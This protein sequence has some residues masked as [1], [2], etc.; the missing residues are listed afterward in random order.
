MFI[1]WLPEVL[2]SWRLSAR[3]KR[4]D[5]VRRGT[6]P[7]SASVE[8]LEPLTLLAQGSIALNKTIYEIPDLNAVPTPPN[9]GDTVTIT[10]SDPDLSTN[11]APSLSVQ[12][13]SSGGDEE[14]VNLIRQG[15]PGTSV[16]IGTMGSASSEVA[17]F[18]LQNGTLEVPRGTFISVSYV[19]ASN[20]NGVQQTIT[21]QSRFYVFGPVKPTD[22]NGANFSSTN[23]AAGNNGFTTSGPNGNNWHLSTGRGTVANPNSYYFG[24][25]EDSSAVPNSGGGTYLANRDGTLT[26]PLIDL[27]NVTDGVRLEFDQ[28]LNVNAGF[29]APAIPDTATVSVITASGTKVIA[30]SNSTV[31]PGLAK[32]LFNNT[33]TV[34]ERQTL[35]LSAFS[36]QKIQLAFR[37][38]SNADAL[39]GEGWYIDEIKLSAPLGSIE[40]TKRNDL[41][42]NGQLDLG[43]PGLAGWTMY[44]DQN[45]N[46]IQDNITTTAVVGTPQVLN[47][48]T[49]QAVGVSNSSINLGNIVGS[50]TDVNVELAI[51]HA[52]DSDLEVT[53]VSAQ[54][55]RVQLFAAV[56]G[57]GDNFAGTTLDDQSAVSISQGTAPFVG[58]FVPQTPLSV[59]N[60]ENPN[61]TWTLEVRDTVNSEQGTLLSW[62]L[63]ISTP[64]VS[65]VTDATGHYSL[66]IYKA[67][68][69]NI[70][71]V[72]Q[73][74]WKQ[75]N[76][77]GATPTDPNPGQDVTIGF[78]GI[79]QNVD[80]YNQFVNPVVVLP[81]D[82]PLIYTEGDPPLT[83]AL[84]ATVTDGSNPQNF[85]GGNLTVS[86]TVN[87]T[88]DDLLTIENQGPQQIGVVGN[89]VSY[90]GVVIGTFTGGVST[91]S[92]LA[93]PLVVTF[94][95]NATLEAVQALMRSV[96]FSINSS[97]PSA[98]TRTVLFVVTD[99]EG[100]SSAQTLDSTKQISVRTVNTPP[101]ISVT[102][103]SLPY[104]QG[105]PATPVDVLATVTDGDSLNF[106]GGSLKVSLKGNETGPVTTLRKRFDIA[107]NSLPLVLND[108]A[109][110][111]N[112]S[113]FIVG[114]V[115]GTL[116]DVNVTVNIT[117]P[118]IG[119]LSA[120]LIG[121]NGTV[122]PLF[123]NL[124]NGGANFTNTTLDN[125]A[126]TA[127]TAPANVAPYTG[128]FRPSG[129]LAALNGINP[130]GTW[131]LQVI[132]L[133]GVGTGTLDSW[134]LD[135]TTSNVTTS[136]LFP[137][138]R[139]NNTTLDSPMTV[140]GL[141]GTL[142][143]VNVTL[144]ILHDADIELSVALIDPNGTVVPLFTNLAN[145]GRNFTNT[146]F[147]D[148][149][150][151]DITDP[152]NFA[153]YTGSFRPIQPLSVL[154]GINPN[155]T[156]Q[157]R[158][159]DINRPGIF[160]QLVATLRSWSLNLGMSN[161]AAPVPGLSVPLN[162][163]TIRSPILVA[164]MN[165]KLSDVNVNVNITHSNV[166]DVS[167]TLISPTGVRVRLVG[168]VPV[169]GPNFTNTTFDD[170][171]TVSILDNS[172]LNNPRATP[173]FTGSFRPERSLT[174]M[175][176]LDP[177]GL[178]KLEVTDINSG[179]GNGF[180][181]LD[182]WSLDLTTTNRSTNEKLSVIN[183]GSGPGVVGLVG[184]DASN[185][186]YV[187]YGGK[188]IG[189]LSGGVG[190]D[191]LVV[192]FV[193]TLGNPNTNATP[194]AVQA[195][196]QNIA[197]E[198]TGNSPIPGERRVE[199]V[200]DDNDGPFID[201]D[202]N[203]IN[204]GVSALATRLIDVIP[205]NDAPVLTLPSGQTTYTIGAQPT[206]LDLAATV[207]D[208][209]SPDFENGI[210]TVSLGDSAPTTDVLGIRSSG[211]ATAQI[212]T[213]GTT[214]KTVRFGSTVIGTAVGGTTGTPLTVAF[215]SGA[216]PAAVQALVRAITF[217]ATA[218]NPD[219][220]ARVVSFQ[221]TDGDGG[222]SGVIQKVVTL[223]K[224]NSPPVLKLSTVIIPPGTVAL[225]QVSYNANGMP[226]L[227]DP[228]ATVTDSD[229]TV[230][231]GG[232]LTVTLTSG[233]SGRDRTTIVNQGLVTVSGT[234][235]SYA[236]IV[237]GKLTAG[238][239]ASPLIVD[240]NST[241]SVDAVQA[242]VR[243]VNFQ[244]LGPNVVGGSRTVSYVVTD[245]SGG[246]SVAQFRTILVQITNQA[247]VNTVPTV[248]YQ[249]Q[250]DV[251]L[252]LA[253]LGVS[254]PD[255]SLATI[256]V[257]LSVLHGKLTLDTSVAGGLTNTAITGN[258][259][260]QVVLDADQF[261]I[262][263]TLGSLYGVTY[264]GVQDYN[265]PDQLT[266]L[267]S[268]QG[269]SGPGGV[270]TDSDLVFIDVQSVFDTARITTSPGVATNNRGLEALLDPG[271]TASLADDQGTLNT[272]VLTIGVT[273]V[274]KPDGT[275]GSFRADTLRVIL[276]G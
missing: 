51:N 135:I 272:A 152:L 245:G 226:V 119:E 57:T 62:S 13:L 127:L 139:V 166:R 234:N 68:T 248:N 155:G 18:G 222:E 59:L 237:V 47:D 37:L 70:R 113:K 41:N 178:W 32:N 11:T 263:K 206:V 118:R 8:S 87:G 117:H 56:G 193:N 61:G 244:I 201:A 78:G 183:Q 121:P 83:I 132:D 200:L 261:S 197:I 192:N 175:D 108:N 65:A 163:N 131:S 189:T 96:Q 142:T 176:G 116:S 276:E 250:E 141:T 195:V 190:T 55:T 114:G 63:T 101:V 256:K 104:N 128:T 160:P 77:F 12:L 86:L 151:T 259:T 71:E 161:T 9:V 52:R 217:R 187:T 153:P 202:G 227:L 17:G 208:N 150:A 36:G 107:A 54:G 145:G 257:T 103:G 270:L 120:F 230:F 223:S 182:S 53:L 106:A 269:N 138:L 125:Q 140:A 130:N 74:G 89:E 173:P 85:G 92:L 66:P 247:P 75:T 238:V 225:S 169:N 268:D 162:N 6:A 23:L 111:N 164:G 194:D 81:N 72:A 220:T 73:S 15:G 157:L 213:T 98:L 177:N 42:G 102:G 5:R 30:V 191:P 69:F 229:T 143:D 38:Q 34:F 168:N 110:T 134:S 170:E 207:V 258:G 232:K 253:G 236:G 149:A 224:I 148:Q 58:R 203:A 94:N 154:N 243:S 264:Q 14:T 147:D 260:N 25:G 240:F 241:A 46:R 254:D 126:A 181:T 122:V 91:G 188:V 235:V 185:I 123:A 252:P 219:M 50:V 215:T 21:A 4:S 136:T 99:D 35:D 184:P 266:I 129:S 228:A 16:Y 39:R 80:F 48:A 146:T 212:S 262:N 174:L 49:A 79:V 156:W 19:D 27:T 88:S 26:S 211:Q 158:L 231:N 242:V 28:F 60:G 2:R 267:T 221:V 24:Q 198:I 172:F 210:L 20:G 31:V 40:G 95:T 105:D 265:G 137:T 44:V 239:G 218:V 7:V 205:S 10:L 76:P 274:T 1:D 144:D 115:S 3:S 109:A 33:T 209:D 45:N 97:D 204:G 90:Q 186:T 165:G 275:V 93:K 255:A 196:I 214:V 167:L 180:G 22:F 246:T 199:F 233:S 251:P 249:A 273:S 64:E 271:I 112:T 43:E 124:A 29:T 67:G 100:G 133:P 171:A 216:T 84:D 82:P 159:I 179:F